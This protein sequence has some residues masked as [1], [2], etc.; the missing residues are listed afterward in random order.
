MNTS[1]TFDQIRAAISVESLLQDSGAKRRGPLWFCPLHQHNHKTPSLSVKGDR[2]RCWSC[3]AYGDVIDLYA[4]LRG[5]SLSEAFHELKA[6]LGIHGTS[7]TGP[8]K[9]QLADT[10]IWRHGFLLRLHDSMELAKAALWSEIEARPDGEPSEQTAAAVHT[11]TVMEMDVRKASSKDLWN[12]HRGFLKSH[13]VSTQQT[14]LEGR[15][16]LMELSQHIALIVDALAA[17][18]YTAVAA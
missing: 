3:G 4:Q 16:D 5:I 1:K 11:L 2:W 12:I 17:D 14:L 15:E 9:D 6:R 10:E 13:P 7:Y 8:S 18:S